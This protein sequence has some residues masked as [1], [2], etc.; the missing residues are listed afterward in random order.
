MRTAFCVL[1]V[2][3]LR[4]YACRELCSTQSSDAGY[5]L[6]PPFAS[7]ARAESRWPSTPDAPCS[8]RRESCVPA[9]LP[10]TLR[11]HFN[12][13]QISAVK[14]KLAQGP[15]GTST[16][17]QRTA[18]ISAASHAFAATLLPCRLPVLREICRH[19]PA[20]VG[21]EPN[22]CIGGPVGHL[23]AF[24]RALGPGA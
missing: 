20:L 7:P 17:R 2:L 24:I 6:G 16:R 3:P 4:T 18:L 8:P 23:Y 13:S 14:F 10:P 12:M 5:T 9:E 19:D 1:Y 15:V 21:I 11:L 22:A